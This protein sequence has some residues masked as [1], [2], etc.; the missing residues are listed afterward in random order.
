[1]PDLYAN[2]WVC[3]GDE[4]VQ[5]DVRKSVPLFRE[6]RSLNRD[7]TAINDLGYPLFDLYIAVLLPPAS[8]V[9]TSSSPNL[10]ICV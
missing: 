10:T 1:M 5:E 3:H 6:A 9:S 2:T 4:L 7:S 8:P